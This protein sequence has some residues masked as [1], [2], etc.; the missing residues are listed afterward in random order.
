MSAGG[1]DCSAEVAHEMLL[2]FAR[3]RF[4]CTNTE[5]ARADGQSM[6]EA[7]ADAQ[8]TAD[9]IPDPDKPASPSSENKVNND[10]L[11]Q[12]ADID[13]SLNQM[14]RNEDLNRRRVGDFLQNLADG[15]SANQPVFPVA[16][17]ALA[18]ILFLCNRLRDEGL[19][20]AQID[21]MQQRAMFPSN[22]VV[23]STL[24]PDIE[25]YY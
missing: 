5:E 6:K 23:Y 7:R 9:G 25:R 16:R 14:E 8:S 10:V 18:N 19:T 20:D 13:S 2:A 17:N 24:P 4:E 3:A 21:I 22:A 15:R 11:D 1:N 12:H